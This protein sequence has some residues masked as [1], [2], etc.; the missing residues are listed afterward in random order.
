MMSHDYTTPKGYF[1]APFSKTVKIPNCNNYFCNL[2]EWVAIL[3]VLRNDQNHIWKSPLSP[4]QFIKQNSSALSEKSGL[5]FSPSVRRKERIPFPAHARPIYFHFIHFDRNRQWILTAALAPSVLTNKNRR[6]T[7][8]HLP[9]DP[10]RLFPLF[11]L[12]RDVIKFE[13]SLRDVVSTSIIFKT[14]L[15]RA[16]FLPQLTT[17]RASFIVL[18]CCDDELRGGCALKETHRRWLFAMWNLTEMIAINSKSAFLFRQNTIFRDF[19]NR[20]FY[21]CSIYLAIYPETFPCD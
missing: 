7:Y 19:L 17:S 21:I 8:A 11:Y 5:V 12:F 14:S 3:N 13:N 15:L 10:L 1:I 16:R 4:E 18:T 6:G 20:A 9:S 2:F